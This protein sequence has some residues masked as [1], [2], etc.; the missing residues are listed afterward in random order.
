M[1]HRTQR[2]KMSSEGDKEAEGEEPETL[3][4]ILSFYIHL[5]ALVNLKILF[6]QEAT[7]DS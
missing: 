5:F 6:Y 7:R 2:D 1:Q 3:G 4:A